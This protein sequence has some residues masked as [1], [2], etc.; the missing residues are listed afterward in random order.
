M[1]TEHAGAGNSVNRG[2]ACRVYLSVSCDDAQVG[3]EREVVLP[4]IPRAG[5]WLWDD[6]F[7]NSGCWS[8]GGIEIKRVGFGVSSGEVLLDCGCE[9]AL[10]STMDEAMQWY[11]GFA[12]I[13]VVRVIDRGRGQDEQ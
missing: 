4:C 12:T 13:S 8:G 9:S 7:G 5:D 3:L 6:A 1:T 11:P 2:I 10:S